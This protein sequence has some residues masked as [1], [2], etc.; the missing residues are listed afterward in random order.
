MNK[1][2]WIGTCIIVGLLSMILGM[3]LGAYVNNQ[4][5]QLML[6][7]DGIARWEITSDGK[8]RLRYFVW[9]NSSPPGS[10]GTVVNGSSLYP[11]SWR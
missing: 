9:E 8:P 10:Y 5:W 7:K 3:G 4:D 6:V 2:D 1:K 11:Y